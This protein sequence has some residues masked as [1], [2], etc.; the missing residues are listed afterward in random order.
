MNTK[1]AKKQDGRAFNGRTS[2]DATARRHTLRLTSEE[3]EIIKELRQSRG[4]I[5]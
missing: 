2:I 1:Q 3:F 5:K 4:L